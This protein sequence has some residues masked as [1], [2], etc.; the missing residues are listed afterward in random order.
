VEQMA[1]GGEDFDSGT[2]GEL[3]SDD[4]A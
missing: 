2:P 4:R 1:G 3:G